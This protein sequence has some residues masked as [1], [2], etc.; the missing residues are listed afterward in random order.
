LIKLSLQDP[1][2]LS[3]YLSKAF[4]LIFNQILL[5][6]AAPPH[7]LI[8]ASDAIGNG[9]IVRYCISDEMIMASIEYARQGSLVE[10]AR[11]KQKTPFLSRL[12][13]NVT[14]AMNGHA[15]KMGHLLPILTALVSRLRVRI[16]GGEEPK[17]DED[18]LGKTAAEELLMDLVKEIG[19]LRVDKG[20]EEKGKVDDV[21]GMAIEVMGVEAVLKALPL[22]IEPNE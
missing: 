19:D 17:V 4:N 5:S 7:V 9:G 3:T 6:P 18:G 12:I 2:T 16:T 1:I 10:G 14:S 22:N 13:G 20:F 15:L 21:V 11:K 8:A